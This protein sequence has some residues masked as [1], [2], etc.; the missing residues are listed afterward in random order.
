[1]KKADIVIGK[2][3]LMARRVNES[4]DHVRVLAID[5]RECT[6]EHLTS[7]YSGLGEN[8]P[9]SHIRCQYADRVEYLQDISERQGIVYTEKRVKRLTKRA[10]GLALGARLTAMGIPC[11]SKRGWSLHSN[12]CVVLSH[13]TLKQWIIERESSANQDALDDL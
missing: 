13:D 9:L 6:V 5:N 2:E 4:F 11:D 8:V 7:F 3:H 10:Q 1:M 12:G